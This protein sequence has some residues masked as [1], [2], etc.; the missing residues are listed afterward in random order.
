[1]T[2]ITDFNLQHSVP[3]RIRKVVIVYQGGIYRARYEGMSNVTFG[4]TPREAASA[5]KFFGAL[6]HQR[7]S[8]RD[9]YETP[10]HKQQETR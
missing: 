10:S 8:M 3:L 4:N 6:T 9:K 1:M 2:P 5:L 7:L